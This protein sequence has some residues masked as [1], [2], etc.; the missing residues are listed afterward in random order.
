MKVLVVV[1]CGDVVVV[2]APVRISSTGA[3]SIFR[4][5]IV[6]CSVPN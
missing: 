4:T 5:P 6:T 3:H 1:D 2:V